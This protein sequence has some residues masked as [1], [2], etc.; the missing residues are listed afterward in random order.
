MAAGAPAR[1]QQ[2]RPEPSASEIAAARSLGQE[3]FRLADAGRCD[4]A[5]ERLARAERLYHAPTLLGRLGEC[6]VALGRLGVGAEN[7]RRVAG[8]ALPANASQAFVL[9]KARAQKALEQALPRV[10]RLRVSV[11]APAE[12]RPSIKLDGEPIAPATLGREQFVDPGEHGVEAIAPGYVRAFQRVELA[13][14][15][16]ASVSLALAPEAVSLPAEGGAR[17]GR[18]RLIDDAAPPAAERP[19]ASP[20]AY[21]ALGVGGAGLAAGALLGALTLA[22]KSD[23]EEACPGG[24]C[25]SADQQRDIDAM[26]RLGNASTAAFALGGAGLV[27]GGLGLWL[28]PSRPD[29]KRARAASGI[30][31]GAWASGGAAG[32]RGKFP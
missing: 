10:A 16:A 29:P 31:L 23:L 13:P 8:E 11:R 20:W 6:Q 19:G 21:V 25:P 14:G 3:G 22:R 27:A 30:E 24:A 15:E 7:L 12:A 18:A 2:A 17:V 9:A 5:I 26:K 28:G 32:L 1:G 4:E